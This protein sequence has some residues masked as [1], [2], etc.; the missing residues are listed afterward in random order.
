MAD[1]SQYLTVGALTGYLKAKFDR[2]PYLAKV[3]LT[4][5]ISN[6]GN[7]KGRHLYF[8]L[9]DPDG[10]S[11]IRATM[12]SYASRLKFEP[13]EGMK[14]LAIGRVQVYEP[15]GSYSI[16]LDQMTPDGIGDLFLALN[17][18]KEKLSQEGLFAQEKKVLPLLPKKIA[19]ITSPT[20]AVVEDVAKTVERR[21]PDAQV[22]L[23]PAV[24]QGEGAVPSL[25]KQLNR[26]DN[27]GFDTVIIGRGGGSIEDL[28][29]FNDEAL[30]RKVAA[31]KTPVIAS[32]G[33]ETDNTLVDLVADRR[34]A[35]PTAA[36][37]LAT[38]VT[39]QNI[40]DRLFE[41]KTR[42]VVAGRQTI[43]Q[44]QQV[45]DQIVNRPIMQQPDRLYAAYQQEVDQLTSRL[46]RGFSRQLEQK[47]YR[48]QQAK[49]SLVKEQ[50]QLLRPYQE[51]LALAST[52]L[53]LVSPLK[54]LSAGYTI[55]KGPKNQVIKEKADLQV[56]DR[57]HLTFADGEVPAQ[58][59]GE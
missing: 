31:L 28:W 6:L 33:H 52:K 19:V 34:A 47:Q 25:L 46:G 42:L 32:V 37:E 7:R 18:L 40:L 29:A 41:L 51:A 30:V 13:K 8:S 20:G 57:V 1:S 55:V 27:L 39:R 43:A 53:D 22:I 2:D 14:V 9:K 11:V 24:V 23:L 45:L 16:I 35:T 36:A 12:F 26:I 56:G 10:K 48:F 54:I 21:L 59:T 15:S 49:N 58:I 38:P 17:Q 4:G 5:E 50:Q 44:R 3:Y